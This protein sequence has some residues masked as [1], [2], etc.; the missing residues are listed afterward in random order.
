MPLVLAV[1]LSIYATLSSSSADFHHQLP[2]QHK[3]T[4]GWQEPGLWRPKWIM[5]RYFDAREDS[6]AYRDRICFRLKNDKKVK[7]IKTSQRPFLEIGKLNRGD[8]KKKMLFET[9][10]E[11]NKENEIESSSG[12]SDFEDLPADGKWLWQAATP[13]PD[14]AKVKIETF[15]GNDKIS[16]EA[17]C[18][19]GKLD[20]YAAKFKRGKI[21]RSRSSEI[22]G[23]AGALPLG[24]YHAGSFVIRVSTHRPMVSRDFLAFQ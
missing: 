11:S 19:W 8:A 2:D 5:D 9:P 18:E 7:I 4:Q 15:E 16:H 21:S 3:Y 23:K 6:P 14:Q 10:S 24:Q 13:L 17:R 22:T 1:L 12:A 20:G